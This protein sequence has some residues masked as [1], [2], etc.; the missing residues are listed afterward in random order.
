MG[1]TLIDCGKIGVSCVKRLVTPSLSSIL[2]DWG[3]NAVANALEMGDALFEVEFE[4]E[5]PVVVE[6]Q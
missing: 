2:T 5:A 4:V 6:Y 3:Y 1:F